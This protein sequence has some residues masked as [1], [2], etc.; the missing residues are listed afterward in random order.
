MQKMMLFTNCTDLLFYIEFVPIDKKVVY[1]FK[2]NPG[3]EE[4]R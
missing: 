3:T 4:G 2:L 1:V